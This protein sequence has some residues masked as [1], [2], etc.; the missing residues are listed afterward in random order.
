MT[1]N[2]SPDFEDKSS[3]DVTVRAVAGSHTIDKPVTVNIENL[4]E[5]GTVSLSTIQPQAGTSLEATLSDDDNERNLI[6]QWYRTSSRGSTGT[7]IDGETSDSY[8]PID[9][10]D[11]GRYLR[12]V[13]SYDDG[14]GDDKTAFAVSANRVQEAP[15]V[16]LPPEFPD[17][18]HERSIRENTRAGRN[19]GAPVT[20]TDGNNDRLTYTIVAS[21][22]FE[23]VE[24]TGQLRTR[25]EL[26]HETS[27]TRT[28][29]VTATDPGG[30]GDTVDVT[31]TVED[32]DETPVVT[33]PTSPEVAENGNTD[34]S[35]YT[36]TDPD[37]KG[38]EWVL[39]GTDRED[40][41]LSSGGV[42][43]FNEVPDYE[44]KNQY[45]VTVEAHEQ[46]DGTSFDRLNV[47]VQVTNVDEP[48]MVETNVEEPRVGQ[49]LRLEVEDEDGVQSVGE[50]K[51]EKGE[52]NS[53]CGTVDNP[54]VT[55]WE[56]IPGASGP[57][58]TPKAEDQGHCILVTAI[59]NDRAGNGRTEQFLTT[60]SVEFGPFFDSDTGIA[61]VSENSP[62]GRNVTQFR[63]RHS[64]NNETLI[65]TLGGTDARFFTVD[66]VSGQ[67][68]ASATPLDYETQPD[69]EAE[70]EIAATDNNGTTATITVTIAVT[71]ECET[72]GEP[73]CAPNV[74]AA[75]ATTL[76]VTWSTPD[77]TITGYDLQY[78]ESGNNGW[79]PESI[80]G[81]DRPHT[82]ENLTKG[83]AY[84]VKV[85]ASN[86][87]GTGEWSQSGTP[88]YV[89]PPPPPPRPT[90]TPTPTLTTSTGG[91]G[92][93]GGG[94]GSGGFALPAPARPPTPLRPPS[95]FQPAAQVFKLLADN[96]T[97]TRVWR[98]FTQSQRWLFYDP[99]PRL[100]PFNTL[101]TI[102]LAADPP[103]V[104]AIHV[105]R[106]QRFRGYQLY[107][108]WNFIPVT[109]QPLA[110]E[111]GAGTQT[112]QELFQEVAQG[113]LERAWWLDSRTQQ[114]KYYG[115]DPQFAAFNTLETVDLAAD[116]PVVLAV[117][118]TR[119]QQF[120][121]Q[122]LYR[123]WNYVVMR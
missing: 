82:I 115:P 27:P 46:G 30:D 97:L 94:G 62:E 37:L 3:Y 100:A 16:P 64:N 120:L 10:G 87:N 48:G 33:G 83:T 85:R 91:G 86:G 106:G 117:N 103:P 112:V 47:T 63:A 56:A 93:G 84:E 21:D 41:N 49:T 71:D 25:V 81:T 121:G 52:P 67:L 12:A 44:E 2:S 98:L 9:P 40:F 4:E 114:W 59:Y 57:S 42:L 73:P 78:R 11:V 32:V 61:S 54:T 14:H 90:S 45:R 19:L 39:T 109:Q 99:Q 24:G 92:G 13:A 72:A 6:W 5:T 66:S 36:S 69:H 76:R 29:T 70:A 113:T 95:D 38:I 77:T 74:S 35:T 88:G 79:T 104:V 1:F 101:K 118:V 20:A 31:I 18:D 58:Y 96:R 123:G 80:T 108:G 34:V 110:A 122:T 22:H 23:I 26:D 17:G 15:P 50:W 107:R 119:R 7:A 102:N 75:S 89:P 111:P 116:T 8:E 53:P 55:N 51:W 65:Y 43:T 60:E 28:V 68:Q 105:T